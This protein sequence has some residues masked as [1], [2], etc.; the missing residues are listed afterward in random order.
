MRFSQPSLRNRTAPVE[1]GEASLNVL[2]VDHMAIRQ[3]FPCANSPRLYAL[4]ATAAAADESVNVPCRAAAR[5]AVSAL[6]LGQ[7]QCL[8]PFFFLNSESPNLC[9][10]R[11]PI[12]A[13]FVLRWCLVGG[14]K[15]GLNFSPSH[16]NIS[17]YERD[18]CSLMFLRHPLNRQRGPF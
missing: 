11:T 2:N 15:V 13:L 17:L 7:T 16:K 8:F 1:T 3:T 9:L 14:T 5:R 4:A 10:F 6:R 18:L 12:H